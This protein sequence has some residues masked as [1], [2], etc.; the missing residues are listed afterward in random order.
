M[1][2]SKKPKNLCLATDHS[3]TDARDAGPAVRKSVKKHSKCRKQHTPHDV[4]SD[5]EILVACL[6]LP[7]RAHLA[8][9][10]DHLQS[11]VKQYNLRHAVFWASELLVWYPK[12]LGTRPRTLASSLWTRNAPAKPCSRGNSNLRAKALK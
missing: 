5:V 3:P 2:C 11:S 8:T 4:D 12:Y 6:D 9:I 10:P 7:S 1:V